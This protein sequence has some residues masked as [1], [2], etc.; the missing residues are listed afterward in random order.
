MDKGFLKRKKK[1]KGVS[2]ILK[3]KNPK[4]KNTKLNPEKR[5]KLTQ[6][7]NGNSLNQ[8]EFSQSCLQNLLAKRYNGNELCQLF[9]QDMYM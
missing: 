9:R 3:K 6:K 8:A 5:T 2:C 1:F 7:T 4:N